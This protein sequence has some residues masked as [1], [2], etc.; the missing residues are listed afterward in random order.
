VQAVPPGMEYGNARRGVRPV[1]HWYIVVLWRIL[2][3]VP[4]W[5][6]LGTGRELH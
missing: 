5:Y 2:L 3:R 4:C 1:R 6:P